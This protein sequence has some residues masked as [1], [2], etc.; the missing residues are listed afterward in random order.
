MA[1]RGSR[2]DSCLLEQVATAE[3]VPRELTRKIGGW[4]GAWAG[5]KS[6]SAAGSAIGA[7]IALIGGQAGPQAAAPEEIVTVPVAGLIGGGIGGIGGGIGGYFFGTKVTETV[8]DWVVGEPGV[9]I[10][11]ASNDVGMATPKPPK[12]LT[13]HD[14]LNRIHAGEAIF[15]ADGRYHAGRLEIIHDEL[16]WKKGGRLSAE[17]AQQLIDYYYDDSLPLPDVG[18]GDEDDEIWVGDSGINV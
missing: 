16:R 18:P 8:Y 5:A 12:V 9:A 2:L 7:N 4:A 15:G 3:N 17:E 11:L 10:P 1:K 6:G 13:P 14:I